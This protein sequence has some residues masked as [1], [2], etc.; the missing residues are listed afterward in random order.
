[1]TNQVP[2]CAG[3]QTAKSPFDLRRERTTIPVPVIITVTAEFE[4][5][6]AKFSKAVRVPGPDGENVTEA[7]QLAPTASAPE[8]VLVSRKSAAFCP[9]N[10]A[11]DID[12]AVPPLLVSVTVCGT[13]AD[14]TAWTA[15][16]RLVESK[17]ARA[18]RI[19]VPARVTVW[20][21]L[22]TKSLKSSDAERAPIALGV[23]ATVTVQLALAARVLPHALV[24][25][26]SREFGPSARMVGRPRGAF[27]ELVTTTDRS[28]AVPPTT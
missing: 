8:H 14:P 24:T 17:L 16:F 27:P 28:V 4:P 11:P 19:P 22:A 6:P 18:G 12:K 13:L 9:D 2:I 23:N 7:L 3:L 1:M 21:A 5:L 15:K 26:K 25:V 20:G 10:V